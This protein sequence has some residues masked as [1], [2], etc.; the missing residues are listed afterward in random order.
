MHAG[1]TMR[2]CCVRSAGVVGSM[3]WGVRGSWSMGLLVRQGTCGAMFVSKDLP[4]QHSSMIKIMG[5]LP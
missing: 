5:T 3:C 1:S 4:A 2:G